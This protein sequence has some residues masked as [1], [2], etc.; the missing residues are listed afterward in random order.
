MNITLT[1]ENVLAVGF[2]VLF[3]VYCGYMMIGS[4]IMLSKE[5]KRGDK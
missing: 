1:H 3:V 5:M 4:M 2:A